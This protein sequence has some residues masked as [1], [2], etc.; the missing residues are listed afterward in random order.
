MGIS[1][2]S[3][4]TYGHTINANNQSIAF[5]EGGLEITGLINVGS[6]SLNE[7]P[8]AVSTAMNNAGDLEYTVTL[9]RATRFLTI[10]APTNFELLPVT[11]TS[12]AISAYPLMGF[13]T[14]TSGANTY[15]AT[16]PSGFHYIPQNLLQKF[17]DFTDNVQTVGASVRQTPNGSVEVVSY[18]TVEFMDCM[19][20]P[21][22][23]ITPQISIISNANAVAEY[24][25]F[26]TYCILKAPI[27]FIYDTNDPNTFQKCLL[28]KTPQSTKGVNF[29]IQETKKLF[30]WFESGALQFRGLE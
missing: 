5:S 25:S 28:E 10:S 16:N 2:Y 24:R 13:D 26:M 4:F 3:S 11:G 9:D 22:T 6:Y 30:N 1:T 20:K 23:D 21:I 15:Q 29:K 17:T 14:D 12:L 19:V 8:A 27:E 7:F 18:G